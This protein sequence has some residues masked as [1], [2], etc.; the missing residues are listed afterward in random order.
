MGCFKL[1][2]CNQEEALE[3][4]GNMQKKCITAYRYGF[5]GQE[6]DNEWKGDG[7]SVAYEAR[8]YDPR[9]GRFLSRDPWEAKYPWQT[10][11]AYYG[12]SPIA[13]V[14]WN[15]YGAVS[16][17]HLTLPTTPYV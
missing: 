14:D 12:N 13:K 17:T 11:Y 16:Y 1:T 9:L 8:I 4:N 2:Y 5:N 3:V 7:N 6:R 10:P 15:G